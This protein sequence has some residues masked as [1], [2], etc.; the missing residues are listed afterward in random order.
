MS[1]SSNATVPRH[2]MSRS[3]AYGWKIATK[4]YYEVEKYQ[5]VVKRI[6][7]NRTTL[8][9]L[10]CCSTWAVFSAVTPIVA[11]AQTLTQTVRGKV[12]DQET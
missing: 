10:W 9:L 7:R 12:V 8:C 5:Q 6:F 3:Y 11:T 1:S 2:S 4:N